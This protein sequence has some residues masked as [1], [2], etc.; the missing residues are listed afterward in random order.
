MTSAVGEE[1]FS[2]ARRQN[3]IPSFP[4]IAPGRRAWGRNLAT[5]VRQ[6]NDIYMGMS[7][8]LP[9]TV[10]TGHDISGDKAKSD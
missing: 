2:V 9:F 10:E 5:L 1:G 4:W 8:F 6:C 3:L 7:D